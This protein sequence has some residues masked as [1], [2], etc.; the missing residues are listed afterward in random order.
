[1]WCT[2]VWK[3]TEYVYSRNASRDIK[4]LLFGYSYDDSLG[5]DIKVTFIATGTEPINFSDYRNN[6]H[7]NLFGTTSKSSSG[8]GE[9][10]LFKTVSSNSTKKPD[11]FK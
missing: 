10:G 6:S 7:N 8:F 4:H 1:M 3:N 11:F 2:S 5:E 9:D